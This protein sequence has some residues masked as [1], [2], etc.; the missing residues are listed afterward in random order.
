MKRNFENEMWA[1]TLLSLYRHLHTMANSIDNLIKRIGI[2]S[3]FNHS[4]YNSTIKDSNKI[5]ELTERKI[6]IINLKVII[7][8]GLNS[9]KEKDLKILVL[10]YV[11]G[12]NYKKIIEL[13]GI[14]ERT[15]FRRKEVAIANFAEN[16]CSFGFDAKKFSNYLKNENWI[17]NTYYQTLNSSATKFNKS[18]NTKQQYKLLKLVLND[19]NSE[20]L[21]SF[22]YY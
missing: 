14:T 18:Q 12:L 10:A 11:D 13:L 20:P 7:E 9:L 8:K 4:V 16:L 5:I 3:A 22:S 2:N 17:K 19:F 6:K 15:Y 1:K 21:R